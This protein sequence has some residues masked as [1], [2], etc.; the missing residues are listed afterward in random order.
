[1]V[2]WVTTAS[3]QRAFGEEAAWDIGRDQTVRLGTCVRKFPGSPVDVLPGIT[4]V[5]IQD[6]FRCL[7][8]SA[9]ETRGVV[10]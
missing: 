2:E 8:Q 3:T 6:I 4:T 10:P 7:S 9:Y 1:V 5:P